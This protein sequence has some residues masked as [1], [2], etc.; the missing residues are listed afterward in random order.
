MSIENMQA[1]MHRDA[2]LQELKVYII[3]GWPYKLK[4]GT[5]HEKISAIKN[6]LATIDGILLK[7]KRIIIPFQLQKQILKQLHINHMGIEKVRLLAH[8]SVDWVNMNVNIQNTMKQ[9]A[10]CL[11]YWQTQLHEKTIPYE[12]SCKPR[13]VV[14]ANILSIN[15]NTPL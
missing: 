12:L 14:G 13:E 2:Q 9:C 8:E 11:D 5:Y 1:A 3:Q 15:N 4:W 7:G 10:T 6:E